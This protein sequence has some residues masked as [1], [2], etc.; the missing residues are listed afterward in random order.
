LQLSLLPCLSALPF[1]AFD[2]C[3]EWA[4]LLKTLRFSAHG[5]AKLSFGLFSLLAPPSLL[6]RG[7]AFPLG[8]GRCLAP[9]SFAKFS[10]GL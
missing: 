5:F 2:C 7:L 4:G 8:S 3:P 6:L 1:C 10:L 9:N